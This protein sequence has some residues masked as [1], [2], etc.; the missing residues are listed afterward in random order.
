M[1]EDTIAAIST[2][3]GEGGI[4]IIKIS[5]P[6]AVSIAGKVFKPKRGGWDGEKSH[7]LVYGH[8]Y[9]SHTGQAVDEVLVSCMKAP[10]TYTREDVVEINCHGGIVPLRKVLELVLA[11]G[12]RMAE[13]GEFSKRAFLNGRLDLA[14]AE[15]IIDVIRSKTEDGLKIAVSQLKGDLSLKIDELKKRLL[16]ILAQVEANID[17]PDEN[18]EEATGSNIIISSEELLKEIK[19][20]VI[21]S[22]AGIVY[23]EGIRAAIIG[24]PNVG[25]S[26]L[27]NAV[28]K[29][30]RAIVTDI[31]GTTRDV[32]E[33]I[34]NI[35][36]IP[37]RIIDTAGLHKTDDLV[38]KIGVERTKEM[39]EQADLVL[40]VLDAAIGLSD[41]DFEII[42][43]IGE[44]KSLVL[45][46]KVDVKKSIINQGDLDRL[47][48]G[49]P[50][51]WISAEQGTGLDK[52]EEVIVEMV[53]GGQI[54][55]SDTLL[56]ANI[57]HKQ[58][59]EKAAC[60]LEE[61]VSGVKSMFPVD[62]VAID[63]RAAWEALGEITGSTVTE[64][65]IDRIFK[66]FCIGK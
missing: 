66:D 40:L 63:L 15:S 55:R 10:Y 9:D 32:I 46:N 30:K 14:Q 2:P 43:S 16:G 50:V 51:L 3:L 31:P 57:R 4:G 18:L 33:E 53:L 52:M 5:G 23:R 26:S 11:E 36:G 49:R 58:A 20:M 38:E 45:V 1:C 8:I 28:L 25:K 41:Q 35:R 62:I 37:L 21:E 39:I 59:L 22:E 60:Y 29:Q 64:D 56:V 6:E 17:F 24:K 44:K 47:A 13:P 27:L 19:K 65:L 7:T 42:D 54:V 34:V 61:A 48:G 12:A